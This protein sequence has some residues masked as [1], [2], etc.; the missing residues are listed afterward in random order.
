MKIKATIVNLNDLDPAL[1]RYDERIRRVVLKW[2]NA[3]GLLVVNKAKQSI[4]KGPASGTIYRK[5]NPRRDHRASAPGE[6]PASDTGT[7]ARSVNLE[8]RERLHEVDVGT[9]VKH[10]KH[11]ELGTRLMSARPWLLPAL[12]KM[13]NKFV[14]LLKAMMRSE[15]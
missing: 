12:H 15:P 2:L 11:L 10:G 4:L 14:P 1:D 3:V 6:A 13:K 7:L 8:V 5:Y 9:D